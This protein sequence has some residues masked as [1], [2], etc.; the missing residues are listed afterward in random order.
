MHAHRHTHTQTHSHTDTHTQRHTHTHR[1]THTQTHSHTDTHRHTHT[2][3]H[4]DTHSSLMLRQL[5]E[6]AA[7]ALH[8][9]SC[10]NII[11]DLGKLDGVQRGAAST[12]KGLG[13]IKGLIYEER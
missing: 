4:T 3:T 1:H 9:A 8:P 5:G 11:R 7:G 6:S 10:H 2:Q 13:G 12:I